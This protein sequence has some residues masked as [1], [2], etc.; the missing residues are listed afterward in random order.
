MTYKNKNRQ[1]K[2]LTGFDQEIIKDSKIKLI[3]ITVILFIS[4]LTG[5][6][7]AAKTHSSYEHFENFGIVDIRTG[8]LTTTFF[9]RLLSMLLMTLILFGCSFT[10][11]TLPIAV[12][13][14]AYRSYLLGLNIS[15][16]IVIYGLPGVIVTLM[17][18]LP[19]QLLALAVLT[20]FYILMFKTNKDFKS[21]GG[22]KIKNQ[23]MKVILTAILV[24]LTICV[25]ESILLTL[26]S[27]KVILVI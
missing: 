1:L 16:M 8:G 26:F 9:T 3:F 15:L 4:F 22:C 14:L 23:K 10:I 19:C 20:L 27:A 2:E 18:A 11:Y 12:I 17:V 6:I 24:M 7:I 5:I 13:F 25:L 21:F